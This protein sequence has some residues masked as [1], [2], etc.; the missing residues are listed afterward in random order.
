MAIYRFIMNIILS[1]Q[2]KARLLD[3]SLLTL[4]HAVTT[5]LSKLVCPASSVLV[6]LRC[7]LHAG[8]HSTLKRCQSRVD[9][10]CGKP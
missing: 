2:G 5:H 9:H 8:S 10:E 3:V 4:L 1:V 6:C 7:W